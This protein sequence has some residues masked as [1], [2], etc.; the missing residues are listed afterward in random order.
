MFI[1]YVRST[2]LKAPLPSSNLPSEITWREDGRYFA[3]AWT[4][5]IGSEVQRRIHVFEVNGKLQSVCK[6]TS[7]AEAG[8]CWWCVPASQVLTLF[9]LVRN[10]S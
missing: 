1:S 6:E 7:R 8:L 5:T 9:I 10:S 2:F 4:N 3:I